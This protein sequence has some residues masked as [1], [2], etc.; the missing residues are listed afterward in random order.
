M[1]D[2]V[3]GEMQDDRIDNGVRR[4]LREQ[5]VWFEEP[6]TTDGVKGAVVAGSVPFRLKRA[7]LVLNSVAIT[8]AG[9]PQSVLSAGIWE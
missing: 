7:P 6:F 5:A 9:S 2:A 3:A 4:S 8:L 1:L